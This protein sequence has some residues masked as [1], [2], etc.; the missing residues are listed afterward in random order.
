MVPHLL[1]QGTLAALVHRGAGRGSAPRRVWQNWL[2]AFSQDP[3]RW[4]IRF[5]DATY[6]V[7]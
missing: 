4:G 2:R 7:S 5:G 1:P 6:C 3:A